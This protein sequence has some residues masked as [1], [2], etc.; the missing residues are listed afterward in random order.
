MKIQ[1]GKITLVALHAAD[2]PFLV[3][4]YGY[5]PAAVLAGAGSDA[6]GNHL[7]LIPPATGGIPAHR[8]IFAATT[9][10]AC[11]RI[12]VTGYRAAIAL[13]LHNEGELRPNIDYETIWSFK[14]TTSIVGVAKN[15]YEAAAVSDDKLQ[16][17]LRSGK[18][19]SS[20]YRLIYHSDVIPRLPLAGSTISSRSS[21][22][23]SPGDPGVS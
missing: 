6:S 5:Q 14:Q 9:W 15:Q 2:A 4:N 8:Q 22:I 7:D 12:P 23:K 17:L 3:N 18:I 20:D 21:R 10:C 11:C 1:Q 13:L 16:G 19:K